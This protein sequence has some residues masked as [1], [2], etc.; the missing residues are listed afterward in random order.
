MKIKYSKLYIALVCLASLNETTIFSAEKMPTATSAYDSLKNVFSASSISAL[1]TA[2]KTAS[3][4]VPLL[5]GAAI[6]L[7]LA[8]NHYM[9]VSDLS[10]RLDQN[11]ERLNRIEATGLKTQAAVVRMSEHQIPEFKREVLQ[12]AQQIRTFIWGSYLILNNNMQKA[13]SA[14]RNSQQRLEV[15]QEK[16]QVGQDKLRADVTAILKHVQRPQAFVYS[17]VL[18]PQ[19]S[20]SSHIADDV[21]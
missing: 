11:T 16:I 20:I 14:L 21:D 13:F 8:V 6:T 3:I 1:V 12:E 15:G 18:L 4:V 5:V 2:H 19:A 7:K 10:K 9:Y 17:R